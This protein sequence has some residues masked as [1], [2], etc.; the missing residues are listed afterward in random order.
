M[1]YGEKKEQVSIWQNG[2]KLKLDVPSSHIY[3]WIPWTSNDVF[4][5][6]MYDA[7]ENIYR[8]IYQLPSQCQQDD[9]KKKKKILSLMREKVVYNIGDECRLLKK[10]YWYHGQI[11]KGPVLKGKVNMY[12]V[13]HLLL[14]KGDT[15]GKK[16]LIYTSD[17]NLEPWTPWTLEERPFLELW[18]DDYQ[19]QAVTS[20]QQILLT[21]RD[22]IRKKNHRIK[23]LL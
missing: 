6:E 17:Q 2:K 7:N 23:I 1:Y 22:Y 21:Y 15:I 11:T 8:H 19:R 3:P 14:Q 10:G 18:S 12:N 13:E 5:L 16:I 20:I 4:R 9:S